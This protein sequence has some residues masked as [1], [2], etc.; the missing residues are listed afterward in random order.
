MKTL[1]KACDIC[2]DRIGLYQAF[3]TVQ[4]EGRFLRG[5]PKNETVVL[6]PRCFQSY[7]DFLN[8]REEYFIY[9]KAKA[10]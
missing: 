10:I 6:C 3:Y 9:Q 8:S 5:K 7:K 2:R 4:S 1:P